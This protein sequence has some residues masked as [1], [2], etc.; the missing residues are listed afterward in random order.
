MFAHQL[1]GEITLEVFLWPVE[2]M[3]WAKPG[4]G[5]GTPTLQVTGVR[6]L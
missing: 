6:S 5:Q 1:D 2:E 4:R 3:A